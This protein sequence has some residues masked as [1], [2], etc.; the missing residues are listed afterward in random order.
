MTTPCWSAVAVGANARPCSAAIIGQDVKM[1]FLIRKKMRQRFAPS[2][3]IQNGLDAESAARFLRSVSMPPW[4]Q[5]SRD[6]RWA[7]LTG[8]PLYQARGYV[9][10]ERI[11]VPLA[12]GASLPVVRMAKAACRS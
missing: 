9:E 6:S 2:S 12:N 10:I 3:S 11:E 5:D 4:P 7:T 8:V 1:S